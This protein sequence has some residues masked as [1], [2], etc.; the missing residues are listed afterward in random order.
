MKTK[1]PV[2]WV[3]WDDADSNSSWTEVPHTQ[4]TPTYAITLGFLVAESPEYY[5]VADSYLEDPVSRTISNTTKIPRGWI[6]EFY[7]VNDIRQRSNNGKTQKVV[8]E[9][10]SK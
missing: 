10:V 6:K 4:L 9:E 2:V 1:Y 5:L 8:V 3:R 7:K